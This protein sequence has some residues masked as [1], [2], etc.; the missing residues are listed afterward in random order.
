MVR[1]KI[2]VHKIKGNFLNLIYI[3]IYIFGLGGIDL[4][5]TC[6]LRVRFRKP[7]K[8]LAR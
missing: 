8:V 3:Y 2:H 7:S 5:A 1:K 6:I 4:Q